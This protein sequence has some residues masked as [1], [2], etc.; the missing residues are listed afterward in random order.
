MGWRVGLQDRWL[1]ELQLPAGFGWA[2]A[3]RVYGGYSF[4]SGSLV[5]AKSL[6]RLDVCGLLVGF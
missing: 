4:S 6:A 2:L 1:V 3:V 5:S